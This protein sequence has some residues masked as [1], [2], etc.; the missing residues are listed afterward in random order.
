MSEMKHKVCADFQPTPGA[1]TYCLHCGFQH[2]NSGTAQHTPV[3]RYE[4]V[5]TCGG[6]CFDVQP[7]PKGEWV[8][9]DDYEAVRST[10]VAALEGLMRVEA[11]GRI[12]P[13]GAEWDAARAALSKAA[14][15]GEE[16]NH[17]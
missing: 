16:S 4:V 15:K 14:P 8:S 13:I 11:G 9:F 10:L 6:H 12:M 17:G 7:A 1:E 5:N 2:A 3:V